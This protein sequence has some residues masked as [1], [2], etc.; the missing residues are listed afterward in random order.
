MQY[1]IRKKTSKKY[2][3]FVPQPRVTVSVVVLIY[4]DAQ[5]RVDE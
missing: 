4:V 3:Y 2:E 5:K 1:K